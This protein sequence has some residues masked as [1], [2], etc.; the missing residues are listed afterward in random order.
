M[1]D[2]PKLPLNALRAFEAVAAHL[3]F[4]GAAQALHVT[5]AAVSSHIKSLEEFLETPLFV[6]HSRSVRLTPQG[7][8]LLPGVQRGLGELTRAVDQL[9]QDRSS[10]LLNI[11]LLGSFLQKWLLPRLGDFYHKHSE[12]DLRFNAS[13][14][15][16]DFMQTDFHAAVRYGGGE[17]PNVRAEKMLDDWVFPVTSPTLLEKLGPICTIGDLNKYPLLHSASEPWVD[18][19]RRVGG[20]TTRVERGPVLDDSASVLAAAEQG[21]GL[22]LAR[23]SLV[24]GDLAAGRLVRPSDQSVLQQHAYYFVAPPH[25]FDLPKVRRFRDWLHQV[26]SQFPPPEGERLNPQ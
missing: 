22:A 11:S 18:W 7:A 2:A 26:C 23:W 19:L 14:E 13:S 12:I 25:N 16:V 10:G 21:H 1:N 8:R 15:M 4:T 20:D 3:S 17:W 9:R 5:T 24:A 6:R